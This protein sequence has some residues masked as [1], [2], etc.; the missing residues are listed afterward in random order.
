MSKDGLNGGMRVEDKEGDGG[1]MSE[2]VSGESEVEDGCG[3]AGEE[4]E[5]CIHVGGNRG[6][7]SS[8]HT[9]RRASEDVLYREEKREREREN[10]DI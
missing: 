5:V 1:R 6:I 8:A 10:R 3:R 4:R 9:E 2:R 7:Y